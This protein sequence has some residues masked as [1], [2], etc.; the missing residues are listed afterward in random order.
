MR[1]LEHHSQ[2]GRTSHVR[3]CMKTRNLSKC[4][5]DV[6]QHQ[7]NFVRRLS[8]QYISAT[9]HSKCAWNSKNSLT[10]QNRYFRGFKVIDVGT[11]GKLV[12]SACSICVYGRMRIRTSYALCN[13]IYERSMSAVWMP[14]KK[15]CSYPR[16]A[17]VTDEDCWLDTAC[18]M[19][20]GTT[21]AAVVAAGNW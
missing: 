18:S 4:S 10:G 9:I 3:K 2:Y 15:C 19:G 21:G 14:L 7:F 20:V 11:P 1:S 13:H 6:R 17:D 5:W 8:L 12:S 16:N